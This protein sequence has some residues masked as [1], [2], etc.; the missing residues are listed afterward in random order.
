MIRG[1]N[2]AGSS[3]LAA[4]VG[5][6]AVL[7]EIMTEPIVL[8]AGSALVVFSAFCFW[9]AVWRELFPGAPPP[10]PDVHRIPPLLLIAINGFLVLVSAAALAGIWIG[11]TPGH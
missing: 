8:A 4:G 3:S 9:A 10:R 11:R 7:G 1:A 6:K 2:G 5:A